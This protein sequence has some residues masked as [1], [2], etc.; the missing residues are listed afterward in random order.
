MKINFF[1]SIIFILGIFILAVL[2]FSTIG[3]ETKKFNQQI[4]DKFLKNNENLNVD[5]KKGR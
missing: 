2:Y 1:K 3:I 5:L 4:V